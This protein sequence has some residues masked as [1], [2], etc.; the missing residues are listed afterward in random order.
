M[1]RGRG[2][3]GG[4]PGC[5]R[6]GVPYGLHRSPG[7]VAMN[8]GRLHRSPD[9]VGSHLQKYF[10]YHLVFKDQQVRSLTT[11]RGS[12]LVNWG[13]HHQPF[14]SEHRITEHQ[15]TERQISER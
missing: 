12:S 11:I 1:F 6:R 8:L 2:R 13:D 9:E 10:I 14:S 5:E 15:I 4:E 7:E 3:E